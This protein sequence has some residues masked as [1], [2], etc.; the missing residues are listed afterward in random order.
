MPGHS[1]Q[2]GDIMKMVIWPKNIRVND[3]VNDRVSEKVPDAQ[4]K[5]ANKKVFGRRRLSCISF[6]P[7]GA[8]LQRNSPP[9]ILF[10]FTYILTTNVPFVKDFLVTYVVLK[11]IF[12]DFPPWNHGVCK[13]TTFRICAYAQDDIQISCIVAKFPDNK[14][15]TMSKR[16]SLL[17]FSSI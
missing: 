6:S 17:N 11:A 15:C 8:W 1:V 13:G 2:P 9:Q 7:K 4:Y 5:S 3:A 10:V 14:P 16:P 12:T